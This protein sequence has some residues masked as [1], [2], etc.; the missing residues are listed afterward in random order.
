MFALPAIIFLDPF[1]VSFIDYWQI[2]H[3]PWIVFVVLVIR[4]LCTLYSV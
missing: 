3:M 4:I 2:L 1:G